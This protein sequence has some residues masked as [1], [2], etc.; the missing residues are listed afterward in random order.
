MDPYL[1][2]AAP[3]DGI[4]LPCPPGHV[5]EPAG[6]WSLGAMEVVYD[7]DEHD[8]C[9]VRGS[10]DADSATQLRAAGWEQTWIGGTNEMWVR[11]RILVAEQA[12]NQVAQTS[13][14]PG[15]GR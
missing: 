8:V 11:D 15:L 9:F 14:E 5:A 2:P 4:P 7:P 13:P 3:E 6:E 1:R 10:L 12:L